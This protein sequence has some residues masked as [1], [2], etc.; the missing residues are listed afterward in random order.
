ME[1]EFIMVKW[2]TFTC[3]FF[4]EGIKMDKTMTSRKRRTSSLNTSK[5][6]N[7]IKLKKG[8]KLKKFNPDKYLSADFIGSAIMECLLNNDPEGIVE[9][10]SIFLD[11]H[12]K[13]AI[14]KEA[15]VSRSTANQ[16][17]RHKN[18]TIKTL[19]KIVSTIAA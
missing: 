6:Q 15:Q 12:N 16:L 1:N 14:F 18:P 3:F 7:P 9:L 5:K 4:M 10:L 8:V 19:A 17:L 13:T 2:G 11:E